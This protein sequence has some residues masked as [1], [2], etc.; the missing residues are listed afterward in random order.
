MFGSDMGTMYGRAPFCENTFPSPAGTVP[1]ATGSLENGIDEA[2][3]GPVNCISLGCSTVV[4]GGWCF[5]ADENVSSFLLFPTVML[6]SFNALSMTFLV[7]RS[8]MELMLA[9][10]LTDLDRPCN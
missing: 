3:S 6:T 4:G 8:M 2:R 10:N 9:M 1:S 7:V 5:G